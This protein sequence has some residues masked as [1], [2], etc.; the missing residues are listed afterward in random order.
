MSAEARHRAYALF[1]QVFVHGLTDA[2]RETLTV[3]PAVADV[4]PTPFDADRAAAAHHEALGRQVFPYE[5]AF[6]SP[7]GLLGGDVS[8]RVR[9]AY[10]TGGF[11]PDTASLEADHVGLQLAYLAHLS[12]AEAEAESDARGDVVERVRGLQAGFLDRH[13]LRWWPSLAV[14][15]QTQAECAWIARVGTLAVELAAGHRV[16]LDVAAEPVEEPES[17]PLDLDDP[18]TRLRDIVGYLVSPARCGMFLSLHGMGR[19]AKAVDLPSGFGTR[20]KVLE[21]LW[22]TAVDHQGVGPLC[23][24]LGVEVTSTR[25]RLR[26]LGGLGLDV[27]VPERRLHRTHAALERVGRGS[28]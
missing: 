9:E 26:A 13:A 3:L 15:L 5:S 7:E 23:E 8:A 6:R 21:S 1:G 14:A 4:L 17:A 11:A 25:E 22:H 18:E 2:V 28:T 19:V 16:G 27:S 10:R 20:V 24:A 12:R